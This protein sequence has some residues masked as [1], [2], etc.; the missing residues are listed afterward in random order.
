MAIQLLVAKVLRD[1]LALL[2]IRTLTEQESET[3]AARIFERIT[4]LKLDLAARD[5][6]IPS[7][8]GNGTT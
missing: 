6:V 8:G 4:E 2:G 7:S 1:E 3:I 5:F